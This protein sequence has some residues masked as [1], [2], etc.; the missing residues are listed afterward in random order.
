MQRSAVTLVCMGFISRM[1]VPRGIRRAVHPV[2]TTK[3]AL[4]PKSI[5]QLR[6]AASPFDSM[7]YDAER[8]LTTK[9]RS[10]A[11][12]FAHG[13]CPVGQ[14]TTAAASKCRNR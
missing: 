2:R 6:R 4:T 10:R 9:R 13:R 14:R 7:R 11:R 12:T 5:K 1:L 3:S 8:R